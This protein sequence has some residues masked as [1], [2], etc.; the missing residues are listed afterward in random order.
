MRLAMNQS[1]IYYPDNVAANHVKI[2]KILE[3]FG[4]PRKQALRQ[5]EPNRKT[6]MRIKSKQSNLTR[7]QNNK[8]THAHHKTTG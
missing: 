2:I 7:T 8:E 6:E 3:E 4:S 5:K 1:G